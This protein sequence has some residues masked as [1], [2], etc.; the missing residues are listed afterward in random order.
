LVLDAQRNRLLERMI[1][2]VVSNGDSELKQR[3]Q[4]RADADEIELEEPLLR[5]S[6]NHPDPLADAIMESVEKMEA[7]AAQDEEDKKVTTYRD[8]IR[9]GLL[10]K[11]VNGKKWAIIIALSAFL[12]DAINVTLV[13]FLPC[14]YDFCPQVCDPQVCGN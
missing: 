9:I 4:G 10:S 1:S 2:P 7:E 8:I 6:E 11:D 13:F 3:H 5:L 12:V 14:L